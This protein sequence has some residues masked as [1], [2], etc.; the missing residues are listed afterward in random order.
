MLLDHRDPQEPA[1][2]VTCPE[3]EGSGELHFNIARDAN[4]IWTSD[5]R[6]CPACKGFGAVSDVE[7]AVCFR[8]D[9]RTVWRGQGC[10]EHND[11]CMECR[12]RGCAD[13]ADDGDFDADSYYAGRAS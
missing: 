3:C 5:T 11:V 7:A 9:T 2:T 4:G 6:V 10:V 12:P 1:T 8:C 13:C